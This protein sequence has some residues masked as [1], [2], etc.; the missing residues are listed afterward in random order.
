MGYLW[1]TCR[2]S[3]LPGWQTP[4]D[5]DCLFVKVLYRLCENGTQIQDW[6]LQLLYYT[7]NNSTNNQTLFSERIHPTFFI[8][9][10]F[11]KLVIYWWQIYQQKKNVEMG[12]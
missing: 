12:L 3:K 5:R 2:L 1:V 4:W 8:Q 11:E 10:R 6:L 7:M 9:K